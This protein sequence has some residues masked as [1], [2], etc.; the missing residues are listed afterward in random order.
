MTSALL[1]VRRLG[2]RYRTSRRA[3]LRRPD[4]KVFEEVSFTVPHCAVV[5]LTG[6]SGSGKSTLLRCL[7]SLDRADEGTIRFEGLPV[8]GGQKR[9]RPSPIQ[10]IPQD[11]GASL[12]PRFTAF[13]IVEEPLRFM[14]GTNTAARRSIVS[15][16]LDRTGLADSW[17]RRK[18]WEF[19]GGQRARLAIARALAAEPRL[20]LLDESLSGL[21]ASVRGQILNLLL[22]IQRW[23]GLSYL[24]VTH[25]CELARSLAGSVLELEQGR[26]RTLEG[27]P[28]ASSPELA[29]TV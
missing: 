16:L 20:L 8:L 9:G 19:S 21:D 7:C 3:D 5:G 29:Y 13:E 26:L 14:N 10:L 1:E 22:D 25:D 6:P 4:L 27:T 17:A 15:H 28:V 18:S 2:K 12:N 24:L 11:P 23:R